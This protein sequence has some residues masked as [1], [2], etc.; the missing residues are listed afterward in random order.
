[1]RA[2][3]AAQLGQL[4]RRGRARGA[5]GPCCSGRSTHLGRPLGGDALKGILSALTADVFLMASASPEWSERTRKV[6]E[7]R[8]SGVV[9][10]RWLNNVR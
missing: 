5:A 3:P 6:V 8:L 4:A 9:P 10:T 2:A 1:V 7:D